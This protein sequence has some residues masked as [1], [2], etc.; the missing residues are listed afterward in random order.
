MGKS[1]RGKALKAEG[2]TRGTCPKCSK[3][4]VKLAWQEGKG[5]EAIKIC[6]ACYA[7]LNRH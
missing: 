2:H 4:R 1:K 5:A 6:K 3:K 7:R